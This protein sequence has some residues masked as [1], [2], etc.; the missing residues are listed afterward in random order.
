MDIRQ[1]IG[2]YGDGVRHNFVNDIGD[3][4]KYALLRALCEADPAGIRLGVIW[5]LTDHEERNGDGRRRA[6]LS[7]SGWET[8]DPSLLTA[9]RD[10]ERRLQGENQLDVRLI[11]AANI[12]PAATA[13]FTEALPQARGSAQARA[14]ERMAWFERARKALTNCNLVFIDPDNGLQPR[15]VPLTSPLAGK[16]AT[17]EEI[18]ALLDTGAGVVLYQHGNRVAWPAQRE[19]VCSAILAGTDKAVTIRT[20]RFGAYGV[21]AFFCITTNVRMTEVVNRGMDLLRRRTEGWDKA[22]YLVME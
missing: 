21:R 17:V 3:Y 10:I 15:S 16:Y 12:L 6:H 4:A 1:S 2:G 22:R 5:Y 13:F 14:A 18:A 8:L 7:D 9:M 11:E 20:L 19:D